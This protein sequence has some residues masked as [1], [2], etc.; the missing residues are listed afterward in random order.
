VV[1]FIV[2][3]YIKIF[4]FIFYTFT[5][6]SDTKNLI[7]D[8]YSNSKIFRFTAGKGGQSEPISQR[9]AFFRTKN[10]HSDLMELQQGLIDNN[11]SRQRQLMSYFMWD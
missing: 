3:I 11:Y 1:Y 6:E 9:W 10:I 2:Y 4:P 8:I 7:H 5:I